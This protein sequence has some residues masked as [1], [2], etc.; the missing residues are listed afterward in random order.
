MFKRYVLFTIYLPAIFSFLCLILI[1]ITISGQ[2]N[3]ARG[4]IYSLKVDFKDIVYS[5]IIQ[6]ENRT[7]YA[8]SLLNRVYYIGLW[9]Y[10][11]TD[12]PE[13]SKDWLYCSSQDPPYRF[14]PYDLILKE[15]FIYPRQKRQISSILFPDG[16]TMNKVD[17]STIFA[18]LWVSLIFSGL[19]FLY[20]CG[21]GGYSVAKPSVII[22][23]LLLINITCLIVVGALSNVKFGKIAKS[24]NSTNGR[25]GISASLG[26]RNFYT[27]IWISL[28][29]QIISLSMTFIGNSFLFQNPDY[30][31]SRLEQQDKINRL[32][33]SNTRPLNQTSISSSRPRSPSPTPS[34]LFDRVSGLER[35][36][37][38]T[39]PTRP[40]ILPPVETTNIDRT[41]IQR[42][43][44]I[45]VETGEAP[46]RYEEINKDQLHT[47]NTLPDNHGSSDRQ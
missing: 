19:M 9:G 21:A 35:G 34:Q 7:L 2:S 43:E 17:N 46:P 44:E 20:Y 15:A 26:N 14:D 31:M 16:V 29:L 12:Y 33:R 41:R 30:K 23:P 37:S 45:H 40:M 18:L 10:C 47:G 8:E 42:R 11:S 3:K 38:T 13:R 5:R 27:M 6:P 24:F 32:G 39:R 28:S 1:A 36:R 25:Y 22:Y 4:S